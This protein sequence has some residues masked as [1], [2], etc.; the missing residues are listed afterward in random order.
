MIFVRFDGFTETVC[1][2]RRQNAWR[3]KPLEAI[4]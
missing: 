1:V 3:Y 2:Q 4:E